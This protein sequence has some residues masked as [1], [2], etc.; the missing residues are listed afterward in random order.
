LAITREL[1]DEAAVVVADDVAWRE[2]SADLFE[3]IFERYLLRERDD[4]RGVLAAES[5]ARIHQY[6]GAHFAETIE[7]D[8]LADVVSKSRSHFRDCFAVRW[9][10]ARTSIS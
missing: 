9:A 2:L 1:A 10:S 3:H 7:V 5:L 4:R 8:V 6:V